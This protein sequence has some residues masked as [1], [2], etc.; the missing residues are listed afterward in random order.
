ME[1]ALGGKNVAKIWLT[2]VGQPSCVKKCCLAE[3]SPF[4]SVLKMAMNS[5]Y[6]LCAEWI[7]VG[8]A[9]W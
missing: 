2:V 4:L 1:V 7:L 9:D 8:L 5:W 6:K 3:K